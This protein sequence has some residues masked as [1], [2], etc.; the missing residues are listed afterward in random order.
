MGGDSRWSELDQNQDRTEFRR[1]KGVWG[2]FKVRKQNSEG[3]ILR[4]LESDK[5]EG[6]ES[7]Q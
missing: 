6:R 7:V 2:D 4:G 3:R 1:D 5:D